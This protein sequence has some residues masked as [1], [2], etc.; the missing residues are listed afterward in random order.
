MSVTSVSYFTA[1]GQPNF[2][3]AVSVGGPVY[4][5]A[6]ESSTEFQGARQKY[7][8]TAASYSAASLNTVA[9]YLAT[10]CYLTSEGGF[11]DVRGGVIEFTREY[12]RIPSSRTVPLGTYA[13]KFPATP[14]TPTGSPKTITAASGTTFTSAA[15]GYSA[16]TYVLVAASYTSGAISVYGVIASVTTDTFVL[17]L[18]YVPTGSF[19]SGTVTEISRGRSVSRTIPAPAIEVFTYALP[20]VTSG[21]NTIQDFK[22]DEIFRVLVT[23]S[24]EETDAVETTTTPTAAQYAALVSTGSYIVADSGVEVLAG[25][26]LQKRTVMV[27]AL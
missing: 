17:N 14:F 19:S 11:S 12:R 10:T 21:V 4:I 27:V 24:G 9:T 6:P 26:I 25:N 2:N 7:W 3:T 16:G 5:S 1:S 23:A 8:Q 18:A 20:G 22:A 13:F 15:H